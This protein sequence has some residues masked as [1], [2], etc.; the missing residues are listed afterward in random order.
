MLLDIRNIVADDDILQ[1]GIQPIIQQYNTEQF[2][3][4]ELPEKD[5]QVRDPIFIPY[6]HPQ[7]SR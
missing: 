1:Q 2:I 4:V 5:Y 3:T 6:K 7:D